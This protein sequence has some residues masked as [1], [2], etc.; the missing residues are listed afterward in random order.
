[1][2]T[3]FSIKLCRISPPFQFIFTILMIGGVFLFFGIYSTITR[4]LLS[5]GYAQALTI[6]TYL[7]SVVFLIIG[8]GYLIQYV[9]C[10]NKIKDADM[11]LNKYIQLLEKD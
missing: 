3:P 10:H 4:Y 8:I 9:S 11:N 5:S 1:M 7:F 2:P 6:F